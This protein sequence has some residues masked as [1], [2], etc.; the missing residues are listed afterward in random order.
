MIQRGTE[1]V[2]LDYAEQARAPERG[3]RPSFDVV[4]GG[5]IDA[6][7]RR[8]VSDAFVALSRVAVVSIVLFVALGISRVALTTAAVTCLRANV[9]TQSAIEAARSYNSELRVE[10][11]VLCD[12]NRIVRIATENY[13]MAPACDHDLV[14]LPSDELTRTAIVGS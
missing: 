8:G 10:R 11:S 3:G 1:A 2:R 6:M 12:T 9:E 5:G 14:Q 13:G 7:A 4:E